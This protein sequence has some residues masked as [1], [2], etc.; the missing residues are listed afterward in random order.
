MVPLAGAAIGAILLA[1]WLTRIPLG[2]GWYHDDGVY[3]SAASA[4]AQGHGPRLEYLPGAPFLTKYPLLWPSALAIVLR[5]AG[6][7][8]ADLA[9]PIV[10]TPIVLAFPLAILAWRRILRRGWGLDAGVTAL[11]L[12]ALALNP[13]CLEFCRFPMSEIPFLAL[14]LWAVAL[15]DEP[16][17]ASRGREMAAACLAV[18]ALHTRLAGAA[19]VAALLCAFA[20]RRRSFAFAFTVVLAGASLGAWALYLHDARAAAGALEA[21]PL[22]AYDLGYGG[23]ADGGPGRILQAILESPRTAFFGAHIALG[24]TLPMR[25]LARAQAGGSAL[26]LAA[27]V[28]GWIV[29]LLLGARAR[30]RSTG[31]RGPL[32]R[33]ETFYVPFTLGVVLLWPAATW[34]LLLPIAP[35]LLALPAIGIAGP[36]RARGVQALA[37]AALVF[38]AIAGLPWNV[39]PVP[40][41]FVAGG[42]PVNAA[43]LDRAMNAVRG[44]PANTLVGSPMAP[45]VWLRT[46][47]RGVGSW[48]EQRV[49]GV[50]LEGRSLRTFFIGD[51]GSRQSALRGVR[52]AIP[53]YPRLGVGA[54][55]SRK[56]PPPD[57]F[58]GAASGIPG[59]RLLYGS[60]DYDLYALP[61]SAGPAQGRGR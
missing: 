58:G 40:G 39:A 17:P 8:R 50:S 20:L 59:A 10:L 27:A 22:L 32:A 46:G 34:R 24:A 49:E 38:L 57:L 4:I 54:A 44:L 21:S 6:A 37:A 15:A 5:I 28:L 48:V 56:F 60:H 7:S 30:L 1:V 31:E 36:A 9:G 61:W 35:W 47:R 43:S 25:L 18:A 53:E 13:A 23:Y 29:L 52:E 16:G 14:S 26:P 42:L 11:L 3:V 45:L 41:A 33:A 19:L 51:G 12:A 2:V 55:L